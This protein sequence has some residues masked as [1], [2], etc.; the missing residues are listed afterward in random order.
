MLTTEMFEGDYDIETSPEW[1]ISKSI[2]EP[3]YA[4]RSGLCYF[5]HVRD[6]VVILKALGASVVTQKA[7][8]LHPLVQRT[9]D[10]LYYIKSLQ[11]CDPEAVAL[12]VEYRW[13]ANQGVRKVVEANDYKIVLSEF[14]EVN[15]ML[16]ADKVQ[17]RM[18][19]LASSNPDNIETMW[20]E[21]HSLT[22]YFDAW[23]AALR[24]SDRQYKE[25]VKRI[26]T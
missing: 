20:V 8:I 3:K 17:N 7:F 13:V 4:R 1:A 21:H 11:F 12:A 9:A 2:L 6:G 16:I 26:E 18:D 24:V 5:K 14:T 10:F 25:L 15:T 23:L 22:K 19:F